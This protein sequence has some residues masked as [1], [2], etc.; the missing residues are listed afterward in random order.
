M[1]FAGCRPGDRN[2]AMKKLIPLLMS[3][4]A[5]AMLAACSGYTPPPPAFHEVLYQPY[6][7]DAGDELRI[8]VFGQDNLT[9]TYSVNQAGYIAFPLIG[10]VPARG[11]TASQI[12]QQIARMLRNG[13]LRDPD[14]TVEV[15]RYRPIFVMGEVGNPGQYSYVPGMTVQKAIAA[16]GGYTP[17]ANQRNVDVTRDINGQVMTGRVVTSDPLLPGDTIYVRE[18]LF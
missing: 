1:A 17:R 9:N 6:V 11:H 3:L 12:E 13:Y 15:A 14:V 8:T 7:I 18:R 2:P 16:A 4:V 5:A 10:A